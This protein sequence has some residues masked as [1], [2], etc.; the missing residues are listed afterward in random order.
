[1][2]NLVIGCYRMHGPLGKMAAPWPLF[3]RPVS[4]SQV[5]F[6][7]FLVSLSHSPIFKH[8]VPP[9]VNV[10][11]CSITCSVRVDEPKLLFFG[12][13]KAVG[14]KPKAGVLLRAMDT[15]YAVGTMDRWRGRQAGG[16][17][18]FATSVV[19]SIG[20]VTS[21]IHSLRL[22]SSFSRKSV[23]WLGCDVNSFQPESGI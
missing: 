5:S 20:P 14:R 7:L 6:T 11:A 22:P 8:L 4:L 10:S 1:M 21:T 17:I 2:T 9:K 19:S 15:A 18:S 3:H 16:T 12:A 23:K 13:V